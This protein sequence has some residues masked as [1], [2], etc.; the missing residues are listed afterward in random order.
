MNT[1]T[2]R[3]TV[4][5]SETIE[6]LRDNFTRYYLTAAETVKLYPSVASF[7]E[8]CAQCVENYNS[9]NEYQ[10]YQMPGDRMVGQL[11]AEIEAEANE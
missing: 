1:K 11:Y 6:A 8:A 4:S 9:G 5:K 2:K 10:R 7:R 3:E